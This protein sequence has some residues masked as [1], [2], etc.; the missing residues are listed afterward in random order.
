MPK[1]HMPGSNGHYLSSF[2]PT[3]KYLFHAVT[4]SF[5]LIFKIT[6]FYNVMRRNLEA[7]W[8]FEEHTASTIKVKE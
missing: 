6:I 1:T 4:N 3:A 5:Y 7:Y 2:K 8:L